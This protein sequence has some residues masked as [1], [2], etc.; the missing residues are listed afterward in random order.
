M[1]KESFVS[2]FKKYDLVICIDAEQSDGELIKEETY[3]VAED[4][5]KGDTTVKLFFSERN[6][7][8][9]RFVPKTIGFEMYSEIK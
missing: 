2:R 4:Q 8:T 6:W 5:C 7:I 1:P 3:T 9:E